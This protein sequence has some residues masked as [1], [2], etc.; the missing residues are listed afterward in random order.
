MTSLC[1]FLTGA[2]GA[3]GR[4]EGPRAPL[5]PLCQ[6]EAS[7]QMNEGEGGGGVGIKA[8]CLEMVVPVASVRG[9][10]DRYF[11]QGRLMVPGSEEIVPATQRWA[12]CL[13]TDV[14]TMLLLP[15]TSQFELKKMSPPIAGGDAVPRRRACGYRC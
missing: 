10:T 12:E 11:L 6:R 9:N 1:V 3:A 14:C 8:A 15:R 5:L 4:P 2:A 7:L 13:Q